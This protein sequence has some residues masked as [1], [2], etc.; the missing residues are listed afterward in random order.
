[1]FK[2]HIVIAIKFIK[3][4]KLNRN[5]LNCV[6]CYKPEDQVHTFTQCQPK[7]IHFKTNC[8]DYSNIFSSFEKQVETI[9]V[10]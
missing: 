8:L 6:L 2:G 5:N 9:Q 3:K 1:M 7:M 4:K 10:F